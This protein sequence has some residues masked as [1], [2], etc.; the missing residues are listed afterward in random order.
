MITIAIENTQKKNVER[1]RVHLTYNR[2]KLM[3]VSHK[4]FH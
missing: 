2:N 3:V 4:H 1:E